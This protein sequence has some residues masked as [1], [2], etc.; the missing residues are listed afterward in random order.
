MK[1]IH[2]SV[3]GDI[4]V[5][6]LAISIIDT[7]HFQRLHYIRQTG[8]AYKVFPTATSSRFEHSIGVYHVTRMVLDEIGK[9]QPDVMPS[10]RIQELLC[11]AGLI[12]DIG[13]GPFSHLFDSLCKKKLGEKN[14]W[15]HHE[16]RSK[17]LFRHLVENHNIDISADEVE[18]IISKIDDPPTHEWYDVL[19]CN[20]VSSMDTDKMDY[21][22]RD[23]LHFGMKFTSDI[24]RL[25]RNMRV[26]EQQLCYCER[27]KDELEL[28]FQIRER[29]HRTIYRHPK[30]RW[31]EEQLLCELTDFV[32]PQTVEEFL[33]WN[34]VLMLQ[35]VPYERWSEVETRKR[36]TTHE[37]IPPSFDDRQ[38]E[39]AR[40]HLQFFSRKNPDKIKIDMNR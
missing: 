21:V 37:R 10:P 5:S 14:P 8:F 11:I 39:K 1:I 18:F 13:H 36:Q 20:P 24:F 26:I 27:V 9:K 34:D 38:W 12:H 40:C 17:L 33:K 7:P 2:C 25:V 35:Q 15:V 6:D 29:M 3:W 22:I 16:Y 32:P 30:I 23:S 31:F 19:I 28:F 4:E